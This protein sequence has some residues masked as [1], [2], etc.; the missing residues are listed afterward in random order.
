MRSRREGG[1]F[2]LTEMLLERTIEG[3][4]GE[5]R[6]MGTQCEDELELSVGHAYFPIASRFGYEKRREPT[7]RIRSVRRERRKE[8]SRQGTAIEQMI[9]PVEKG[10]SQSQFLPNCPDRVCPSTP[11]PKDDPLGSEVWAE[12]LPLRR[13][14]DAGTRLFRLGSW[15]K[16]FR[17]FA[18]PSRGSKSPLS[19]YLRYPDYSTLTTYSRKKKVYYKAKPTQEARVYSQDIRKRKAFL[20]LDGKRQALLPCTPS[21]LLL[22]SAGVRLPNSCLHIAMLRAG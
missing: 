13:E 2:S 15:K 19:A 10:S 16:D 9:K 6:E 14:I 5:K 18:S 1:E 7:V 17:D 21:I 20:K 3:Q 11:T 22:V 12:L 8:E 4:S